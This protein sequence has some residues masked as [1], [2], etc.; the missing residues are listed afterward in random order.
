MGTVPASAFEKADQVKPSRNSP[1]ALIRLLE[2][3][4]SRLH[5]FVQSFWNW[6]NEITALL[7]QGSPVAGPIAQSNLGRQARDQRRISKVQ[8]LRPELLALFRAFPPGSDTHVPR[9]AEV[10]QDQLGRRPSY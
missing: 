4:A 10:P 8:R 5:N 3:T 7:T 6:L 9:K 2:F 1:V